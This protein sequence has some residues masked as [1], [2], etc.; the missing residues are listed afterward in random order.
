MLRLRDVMTPSVITI[1]QDSSLRDAMELLSRH[2]ISGVPVESG[3]ELVGVVSAA[4]LVAFAAQLPGIP[5]AGEKDYVE[6]EPAEVFPSEEVD[7]PASTYFLSLWDD[8]GA[9]AVTRF[10]SPESPEWNVLEQYTVAEVMTRTPLWT[11][12]STAT[13]LAA[14]EIMQRESIHRVLV[15]DEGKLAG[16]VTVADITRVASENKLGK[17]VFVFP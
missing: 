2:H 4:D 14:A 8:A 3:G 5:V 12:P 7:D 15:V 10:G 16:I 13:V 11:L 17:R 9:D 1:N 6:T